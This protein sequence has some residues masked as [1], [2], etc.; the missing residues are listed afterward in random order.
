MNNNYL[1]NFSASRLLSGTRTKQLVLIGMTF[2]LILLF[3]PAITHQTLNA[4]EENGAESGSY[5]KPGD[6]VR[7]KIWRGGDLGGD[8]NIDEDGKLSLP[9]L[10]IIE[11]EEL[12]TDSLKLLLMD[13]YSQYLKDPYI[14]VV[15][16]FRI[17]VM[18]EVRNPGLY[19]V[20]ATLSLSDIL[21][22]AGGFTD[23]GDVNK[24]KV[25]QSGQIVTKNLNKELDGDSPIEQFGIK[26]GDQIIIGEKGGLSVTE[27]TIIASMLSATAIVVDV[28]RR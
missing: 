19:P 1:A 17:N 6:M 18:G 13:R 15:P 5:L 20:D 26:S 10:G 2:T 4:S 28:I 27:W 3:F 9:L 7:I 24:I 22:L 12:S 14:T 23:K 16:L 21:S 11:I 8:F 25:M